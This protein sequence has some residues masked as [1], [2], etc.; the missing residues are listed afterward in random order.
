MPYT[1]TSEQSLEAIEKIR[2]AIQGYFKENRLTYAVFGKSEGLDSS[3][4]AGLLSDLPGVKPIGVIM[5][6][7]SDPD[8]EVIAPATLVGIA[9]MYIPSLLVQEAS[10]PARFFISHHIDPGGR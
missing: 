3:V 10:V 7:E 6:C 1:L 5:P 2:A 8:A 4:I 9:E